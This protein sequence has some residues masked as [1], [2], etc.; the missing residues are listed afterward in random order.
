[1]NNKIES[2]F[3]ILAGIIGLF[4]GGGLL[5]F[6]AQLQGDNGIILTSASHF[7]EARAPGAAMFSAAIFAF[8]SV[9]RT[10]WRRTALII[11]SLFFLSYGLGRLLS[12][13]LDGMPAQGLF[14]AIIVEL[15]MG[16]LAIIVLVRMKVTT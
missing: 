10:N 7:S 8:I 1:M 11:M 4:V 13:I 12:L 16:M 14:Y 6:P 2:A 5:F 3:L 15:I 9:F